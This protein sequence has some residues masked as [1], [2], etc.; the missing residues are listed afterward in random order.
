MWKKDCQ[1]PETKEKQAGCQNKQ[2]K[3]PRADEKPKSRKTKISGRKLTK[4]SH[5]C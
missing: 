2:W 5:G 3:L 4:N 1:K